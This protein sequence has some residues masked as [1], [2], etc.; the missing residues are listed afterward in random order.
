MSVAELYD[1]IAQYAN[2]RVIFDIAKL[3]SDVK[4]DKFKEICTNKEAQ[5][6][7]ASERLY[8]LLMLLQSPTN[9][10]LQRQ[11]MNY[12]QLIIS[13]GS[14]RYEKKSAERN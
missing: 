6:F 2:P 3:L 7:E 14:R 5:L 12:Y 8:Q 13:G 9:K 10:E 11:S 4:L 1:A